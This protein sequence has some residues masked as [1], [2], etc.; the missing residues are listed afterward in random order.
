MNQ[1]TQNYNAQNNVGETNNYPNNSITSKYNKAEQI[2]YGY[3]G[4]LAILVLVLAI[5]VYVFAFSAGIGIII[6][7]HEGNNFQS[8]MC[9]A[10][11]IAGFAVGTLIL[12]LSSIIG[13][14]N[15]QTKL[16]MSHI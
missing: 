4:G 9:A 13:N 16:L 14:L 1:G 8:N 2:A 5:I 7:L 10:Y 3:G 15:K 11:F 12:A 6:N